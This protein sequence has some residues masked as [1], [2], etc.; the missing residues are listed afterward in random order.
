MFLFEKFKVYN[1]S[2]P[3][4]SLTL[5]FARKVNTFDYWKKQTGWMI[6]PTSTP[7]VGNVKP[8]Q[9]YTCCH[10]KQRNASTL[11]LKILHMENKISCSLW[12]LKNVM[13]SHYLFTKTEPKCRSGM[14]QC[15]YSTHFKG[16]CW[17]VKVHHTTIW[18]RLH[19]HGLFWRLSRKKTLL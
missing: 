5:L 15:N 8:W 3:F 6:T 7:I 9:R 13:L 16:L 17:N 10:V 12:N 19:K 2:P 14:S 11:I 4:K 18:K 1:I